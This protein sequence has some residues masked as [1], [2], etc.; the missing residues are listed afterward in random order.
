[1]V[2]DHRRDARHRQ[3]GARRAATARGGAPRHA[4]LAPSRVGGHTGRAPERRSDGMTRGAV[5]GVGLLG[6]AGAKRL[7]AGGVEVAGRDTRAG[8]LSALASAGLRPARSVAEAAAGAD[9]VFTILPSLDAV[10]AVI[11]GAD[12]LVETA[13]RG[14]TVLQMST[15]SPPLT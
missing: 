6:S 7:L 4:A 9:A 11:A 10:E 5:I 15:I 13:P 1:R 14:A 2:R 12:G 3:R 8:Q